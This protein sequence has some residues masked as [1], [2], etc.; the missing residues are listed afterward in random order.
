MVRRLLTA[1]VLA[2]LH[3]P[4]GVASTRP[5]NALERRRARGSASR[6]THGHLDTL[7]YSPAIVKYLKLGVRLLDGP[8][9]QLVQKY[10]KMRRIFIMRP[11]K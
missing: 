3:G 10:Q 7:G 1:L 9:E 5:N 2:L 6:V 4:L 11:Q 8:S